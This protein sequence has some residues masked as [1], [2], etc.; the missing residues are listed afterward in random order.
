MLFADSITSGSIVS[1][2]GNS[3]PSVFA[4]ECNPVIGWSPIWAECQFGNSVG[5][6]NPGVGATIIQVPGAGFKGHFIFDASP[7]ETTGPTHLITLGD[8]NRDKTLATQPGTSPTWD[9]FDAYI[10][11]DSPSNGSPMQVSF[12]AGA[13]LSQYIANVGDGINFGERLTATQKIFRVPVQLYS[14]P[15]SQLAQLTGQSN[16]SSLYCLD[17]LNVADDR[18]SFDSDAAPGGH[19]SP[20]IL[21]NGRWRVH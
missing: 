11:Y 6:D 20:L 5:L 7:P 15:Y 4:Q 3:Y 17:C 16:G 19:G 9:Q 14:V 10:G 21:E 18:A 13:S 2:A 8:S 1:S 12:G